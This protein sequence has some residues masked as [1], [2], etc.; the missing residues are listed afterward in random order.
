M[1]LKPHF[2]LFV[3]ILTSLSACNPY[4]KEGIAHLNFG[5]KTGLTPVII[6][7]DQVDDDSS[8]TG[9]GGGT[10]IG[11]VYANGVLSLNATTNYAELD[12]SWTPQWESIVSYWKM[13]ESSWTAN[14]ASTVVDSK[15]ANSA[16]PR[17]NALTTASSKIGPFAGEFDGTNGFVE[18]A[19]N[20]SLNHSTGFTVSAWVRPDNS[21][22]HE[23][24]FESYDTCGACTGWRLNKASSGNG[25]FEFAV[26]IAGVEDIVRSTTVPSTTQWTHLVGVRENDGTLKLYVN[27]VMEDGSGTQ[28]GAITQTQPTYIG[29]RSGSSWFFDGD[30]DDVAVWDSPLTAEEI[31]IIY[32]RQ[33]AK[34]AGETRS[35][36]ID[37]KSMNS[38]W[39]NLDWV[40]TLPF[41]KELPSGGGVANS[42]NSAA[43]SDLYS[44][45]LMD[46]I[47][48]LWHLNELTD[49]GIPGGQDSKDDS[50]YDNYLNGPGVTIL[51]QFGKKGVLG[52]SIYF[53]DTTQCLSMDNSITDFQ[54]E[55]GAS[56]G[57]VAFW[58]KRQQDDSSTFYVF[59][60]YGGGDG[61]HTYLRHLA[62]TNFQ[63][64]FKGKTVSFPSS[65]LKVNKWHHFALTWSVSGN[66]VKAYVDG[67]Q[68]GTTQT[69]V[70]AM[71][72]FPYRMNI[73]GDQNCNADY[74]GHIDEFGLWTRAL[75]PDEITQLY[76]RGANRIK[77]QVRTC[78]NADCSDHDAVTGN[79]WKGPGGDYRTY[80]SELYNNTSLSSS[81]AIA[82]KCFASELHLDGDVKT[83]SP[84]ISFSDFGGDG[85]DMDNNRYFQYRVIMESDDEGTACDGGTSTCMPELKSVEIGPPHSYQE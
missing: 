48:G 20:P 72:L 74:L 56:E 69:T 80:F 18:I 45:S 71:N 14:A 11:T 84:S 31:D 64:H 12:K 75:S 19:T 8:A 27:G 37:T 3:L 62:S 21:D 1:I 46:K 61:N 4:G 59:S 51:P 49:D 22:L 60:F 32:S 35:R 16:T 50:G 52:N 38:S 82:Q 54:N 30:I 6:T 15:G 70:V 78:A 10:H 76:R 29:A 63:A 43:Y 26:R 42:E 2:F 41:G 13:D 33:S 25:V 66:A 57:S 58:L 34:Y 36:I 28:L 53:S 39:T 23:S 5:A 83:T 47:V 9:F 17:G 81:C 79:G 55:G 24:I 40:T 65:T 77:Y 7:V 73:S 85:V 67:K 44:D 68:V